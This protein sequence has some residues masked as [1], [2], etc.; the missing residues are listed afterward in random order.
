[1]EKT[2]KCIGMTP[3]TICSRSCAKITLEIPWSLLDDNKIPDR[4]SFGETISLLL[5]PT[6]DIISGIITANLLL[7]QAIDPSLSYQCW[8]NLQRHIRIAA[9][10]NLLVAKG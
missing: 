6:L 7:M 1:M 10:E 2:I 3:E 4:E 9:E 8:V 5:E